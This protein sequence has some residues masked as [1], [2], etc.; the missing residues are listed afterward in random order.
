MIIY[1]KQDKLNIKF[2]P[3]NTEELDNPDIIISKDY[4]KIGD[5]NISDN[6]ILPDISA[7]DA[8]K[9]V[10][11][12]KN[13]EEYSL[14]DIDI[15]KFVTVNQMQNPFTEQEKQCARDNIGAGEPLNQEVISTAVTTWMDANITQPTDPIVDS[16][17]SVSGAAADA[18]VTGDLIRQI[19]DT[20]LFS[21]NDETDRSTDIVNCLNTYGVCYL[22]A[23]DYYVSGV[24]MPAGS[25]LFGEG[26]S[27]KIYFTG[28]IGSAISMNDLCTCRGIQ[29]V[30]ASSAITLDG[31][32]LGDPTENVNAENLWENG[33]VIIE[34]GFTHLILDN[35]LNPGTY[36][37]SA[38]IQAEDGTKYDSAYIGFSTKNSTTIP[39][40]SIVGNTTI[41]RDIRS[42]N[43]V[44]ISKTVY[45][46]RLCVSTSVTN[47]GN[48]SGT[49]SN[50]NITK[51][52]GKSGISCSNGPFRYCNISN[53]RFKWF[54][55]AGII[56]DNTGVSAENH[57]LV[58]DCDLFEN[59]VG[60][61]VRKDSEY[62]RFT[63]C[64]CNI[65]YYGIL[66]RGGN[67]YFINCGLDK[68]KINIQVDNIEGSNWAHSSIVGCSINH[69]GNNSGYGL[70]IK[71][72]GQMIINGCNFYYSK[73]L[74]ENTN[75]N[76]ISSCGFG[77]QS[78]IEIIGG[79]CSIFSNCMFRSATDSPISLV[80]NTL[81]K[82]INCFTRAGESI[83]LS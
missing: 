72:T 61:Y 8:D 9:F 60:I 68:N 25:S 82:M 18:K 30:G 65:N 11:V 29:F 23:G 64:C 67:N 41:K 74:L 13:G 6:N 62:N 66:N 35:P 45:S 51:C 44:T 27:T 58:S 10:K 39:N 42:S 81:V 77:R 46:V 40:S 79:K 21:T 15:S 20:C 80:N 50:I 32:I 36:R 83:T 31:D 73:I 52:G 54:D 69:A 75:G 34:S 7:Y 37:I 55:C 3:I 12:D 17:L 63:N 5:K 14:V 47:S 38:L 49:W 78:N 33:N 59:N 16:S 43:F 24:Q 53:C 56:F 71:G 57:V 4:V 28:D 48:N 70:I 19:N 26:Q 2:D 76:V 22:K 1:E